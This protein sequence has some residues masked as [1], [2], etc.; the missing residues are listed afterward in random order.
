VPKGKPPPLPGA[1]KEFLA[2]QP[3][4]K[5]ILIPAAPDYRPRERELSKRPLNR[6]D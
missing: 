2:A 4:H 5:I 6:S 3:D 1:N